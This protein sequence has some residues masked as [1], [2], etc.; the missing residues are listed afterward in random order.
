MADAVLSVSFAGPL[1]TVQDGG[2]PG[3]M[4]FG[5]AAS[6]PMD[7]LSFAA[8]N[9]ALGNPDGHAGIEVSLGGLMLTCR[10]G[11]V[12]IAITGGD[13]VVEHRGHRSRSWTVLTLQE[14]DKLAVRAGSAGSWAYLAS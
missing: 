1:V 14:G 6:G 2:R 4:R 7:D 3:H 5:V 12:T 11:A 8:A 9:A 10:S 13:F